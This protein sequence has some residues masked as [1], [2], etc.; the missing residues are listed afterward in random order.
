MNAATVLAAFR[1]A[2]GNPVPRV[3]TRDPRSFAALDIEFEFSRF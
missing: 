3:E 2:R 1:M